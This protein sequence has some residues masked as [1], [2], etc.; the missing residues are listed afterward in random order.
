MSEATD[1]LQ[2]HMMSWCD[3]RMSCDV[4]TSEKKGQGT[5]VVRHQRSGVFTYIFIRDDI[6]SSQCYFNLNFLG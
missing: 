4:M 5:N 6:K 1:V 2:F 3:I